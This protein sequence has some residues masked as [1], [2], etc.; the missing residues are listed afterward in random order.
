MNDSIKWFFILILVI[1]LS[2]FF[3]RFYLNSSV[4]SFKNKKKEASDFMSRPAVISPPNSKI[5]SR[6][7]K[8]A[9][10]ITS[11]E[12]STMSKKKGKKGKRAG[13]ITSS[14]ESTMSKKK[15][16]KGK[17]AG[18]ITSS[19][20]ST[21]SKK[22]GRK[23]KRGGSITSSEGSTMSK[24]QMKQ[25]LR[26]NI[27]GYAQMDKKAKKQA[28]KQLLAGANIG[29]TTEPIAGITVIEPDDFYTPDSPSE[30]L[31]TYLGN[32]N[33]T[34]DAQAITPG[35][36]FTSRANSSI[37]GNY[38]QE[39]YTP[40]LTMKYNGTMTSEPPQLCFQTDKN[41]PSKEVCFDH[42]DFL[43]FNELAQSVDYS[44]GNIEKLAETV[45]SLKDI[46]AFNEDKMNKLQKQ[47]KK[48]KKSSKGS[49]KGSGKGRRKGKSIDCL[50]GPD[51][52]CISGLLGDGESPTFKIKRKQKDRQKKQ[53]KKFKNPK[54]KRQFQMSVDEEEDTDEESI[55]GY[56]PADTEFPSLSD[57]GGKGKKGKRGKED[58]FDED[59]DIEGGA[60]TG[61]AARKAARQAR[62][63]NKLGGGE[64]DSST[65]SGKKGGKKKNKNLESFENYIPYTPSQSDVHNTYYYYR[66]PYQLIPN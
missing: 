16:K 52:V 44:F 24:K 40:K 26:Q 19:E 2:Y 55:D 14:E 18:S 33:F 34:T 61:K 56:D 10:S 15:G 51:G 60:L 20:G 1:I 32:T 38:G 63:E 22:K 17:R 7:G 21:K 4:E 37:T 47:F 49:G 43:R 25:Y 48:L 53:K 46:V 64:D 62:K 42:E 54:K 50:V 45:V 23:G 41:D 12:E 28:K 8:R 31:N 58:T 13:S 57:L 39:V 35:S 27:P 65:G 36:L 66:N 29:L 6:K 11:S 3:I 59:E 5:K 30:V 9:G